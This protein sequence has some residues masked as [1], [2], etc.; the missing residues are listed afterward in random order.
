VAAAVAL[1]IAV[2][3]A[4]DGRST[5]VVDADARHAVASAALGVRDRAGL[6][7]VVGT[8][9]P[10]EDVVVP[11]PV[12]RGAA[13]HVIPAGGSTGGRRALAPGSR[14]DGRDVRAELARLARTFDITVTSLPPVPGATSGALPGPGTATGVAAT[15][16]ATPESVA[17]EVLAREV[18]VCA[19][20]GYTPLAGLTREIARLNAL[21]AHVRGLVIWDDDPPTLLA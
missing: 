7:D 19:R 3:A 12:G 2:A 10:V 9:L 6:A 16:P 5:L 1:N 11:V 14:R 17:R 8:A 18:I 15:G 4:E 13:L 21:G 20:A